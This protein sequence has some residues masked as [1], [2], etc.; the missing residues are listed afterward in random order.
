[1]FQW[2]M[3]QI[4]SFLRCFST[5]AQQIIQVLLTGGALDIF[6]FLWISIY[7]GIW[8]PL[9]HYPRYY[10]TS[11]PKLELDSHFYVPS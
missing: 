7:R 6:T 4:E 11:E 2:T 3:G 1:M 5:F 10:N 8:S 9:V